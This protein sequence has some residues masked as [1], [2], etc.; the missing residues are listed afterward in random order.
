MNM[1]DVFKQAAE[2]LE[3]V[4]TR[5]GLHL[6]VTLK[7][8]LTGQVLD[9]D[10]A[11]AELVQSQTGELLEEAFPG[12]QDLSVTFMVFARLEKPSFKP[13]LISP[14]IVFVRRASP[15]LSNR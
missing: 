13:W 9:I 5:L 11:A 3:A 12:A 7:Q 8:G 1:E 15:L 2:F 14:P 10:G 4:F 6:R